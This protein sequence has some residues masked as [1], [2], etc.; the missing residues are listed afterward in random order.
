V[1]G[2]GDGEKT[3]D[4]EEDEQPAGERHFAGMPLLCV[5]WSEAEKIDSRSVRDTSELEYL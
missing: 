3:G 4:G 1:L 5:M 2:H